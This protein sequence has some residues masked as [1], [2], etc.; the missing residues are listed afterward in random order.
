METAEAYD[1]SFLCHSHFS[2]KFREIYEI[3]NSGYYYQILKEIPSINELVDN[4]IVCSPSA[5]LCCFCFCDYSVC[6]LEEEQCPVPQDGE[7]QGD[8]ADN[9]EFFA[10]EYV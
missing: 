5:I 7:N 9:S 8:D 10:K 1:P 3:M 2:S 6:I 4:L